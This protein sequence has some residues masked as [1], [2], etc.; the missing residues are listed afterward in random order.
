MTTYRYT[1]LPGTTMYLIDTEFQDQPVT[2]RVV[3]AKDASELDDLVA[4]HLA[5]MANPELTIHQTA[6]STETNDVAKM[7]AEL[8]AE[9]DAYK[10]A[11]P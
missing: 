4:H 7:L 9:F 2:F 5:W 11:H 8:R 1:Q 3:V 6:S 10:A